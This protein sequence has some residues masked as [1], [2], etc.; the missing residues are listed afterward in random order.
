M[1][2]WRSLSMYDTA[3][4]GRLNG[5]MVVPFGTGLI[6]MDG[7]CN[8][9]F[10]QN[11]GDSWEVR[12]AVEIGNWPDEEFDPE[13]AV[14]GD[15]IVA[16]PASRS[17]T[18][19]WM[20]GDGGYTWIQQNVSIELTSLYSDKSRLFA[21]NGSGLYEYLGGAWQYIGPVGMP[22]L[23]LM[24][25][26]NLAVAG[27]TL[28]AS[29]EN[30]GEDSMYMSVD[31]G[32][33]WEKIAGRMA[34][35]SHHRG[36][37]WSG[38]SDSI[39]VFE[40]ESRAWKFLLKTGDGG[41][42]LSIWVG[43]DHAYA[44]TSKGMVRW[45]Q[46]GTAREFNDGLA[47]HITRFLAH[48]G[49]ALYT[50]TAT[51]EMYARPEGDR[52]WE[53]REFPEI[54]RPVSLE[55]G[56]GALYTANR[57]ASDIWSTTDGGF[58][59]KSES[60][61]SFGIT[62]VTGLHG[63]GE[64]VIAGD[65]R[66]LVVRFDRTE[67]WTPFTL[68]EGYSSV[69]GMDDLAGAPAALVAGSAGWALMR[70]DRATGTSHYEPIVL[71]DVAEEIL[72]AAGESVVVIASDFQ[73]LTISRDTGRSWERIGVLPGRTPELPINDFDFVYASDK[74]L[75]VSGRPK[76]FSDPDGSSYLISTDKGVTWQHIPRASNLVTDAVVVDGQLHLTSERRSVVVGGFTLSVSGGA[77]ETKGRSGPVSLV[78]FSDHVLS[79]DFSE[80]LT[81]RISLFDV[82]G[83]QLTAIKEGRSVPGRIDLPLMGAPLQ[84]GSYFIVLEGEQ[85]V[86]QVWQTSVVQ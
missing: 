27:D 14:F 86:I 31:G 57:D 25:R 10:S 42:V 74:F 40:P 84:T 41:D 63:N 59:W 26:S 48:D 56:A 49:E 39:F 29:M 18:R 47:G 82:R 16:V 73:G 70:M 28:L 71:S 24:H 20:S 22:V 17:R 43:E 81:Y 60:L 55:S 37:F 5:Q 75:F 44:G 79:L 2:E 3:W 67:Q 34:V 68:G 7:C 83:N 72:F 36:K 64:F 38:R 46:G 58:T 9:I 30:G 32:G 52:E 33:S 61:A 12:G 53:R 23:P 77:T 15:T 4:R 8:I 69:R 50:V 13:I 78:A 62:G 85:G 54:G 21:L 45:E 76:R 66:R 11:G 19:M 51:S 35:L 6:G 1:S 80:S 65:T